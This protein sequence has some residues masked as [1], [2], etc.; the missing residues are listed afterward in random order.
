MY[1]LAST[2]D[3]YLSPALETISDKFSCS[4]SLAG[5]T[6]LALGNGAP[7]VFAAFSAGGTKEDEINL[8]IASL[9]GSALFISTVVMFIT[10][11][12]STNDG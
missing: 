11:K 3:T 5:V 1:N 8:L 2:A 7:D 6:L 10:T 4:E 9:F 12:A